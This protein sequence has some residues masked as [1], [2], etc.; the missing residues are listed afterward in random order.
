MNRRID[1]LLVC[2]PT[3]PMAVALVMAA[4][5]CSSAPPPK[6]TPVHVVAAPAPAKPP[7]APPAPEREPPPNA[8]PLGDF[9]LPTT[10][11]EQLPSGLS[12]GVVESRALPL[13][14]IRVGILGG[15]AADGERPGLAALT[16]ELLRTGG[17]G[18]MSGRDEVARI[19]SLGA[20]L[21]VSADFDRIT[22]RMTVM[23]DKLSEALR[24][25]S[26]IVL[27]PQLSPTAFE[28]VKKQAEARAALRSQRDAS[29]AGSM[30]LFRDS[31]RSPSRTSGTLWHRSRRCPRTSRCRSRR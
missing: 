2:G 21:S 1:A 9:R 22:L 5:A 13:T 31:G 7:P 14:E 26:D 20:D 6:P 4:S 23:K 24:V 19:E 10:T 16:A 28:K 12:V 18:A 15:S 17:A 29:Y 3:I 30:V 27:R 11:W 25:M 8:A